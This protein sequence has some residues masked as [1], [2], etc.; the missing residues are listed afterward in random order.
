VV[1]QVTTELPSFAAVGPAD[2][3]NLATLGERARHD[4]KLTAKALFTKSS[5]A[6][7]TEVSVKSVLA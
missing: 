7:A 6:S 1:R 4:S 2:R 3:T 5:T